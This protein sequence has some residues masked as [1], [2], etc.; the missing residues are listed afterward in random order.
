MLET[1]SESHK[2]HVAAQR[3]ARARSKSHPVAPTNVLPLTPE[4]RYQMIAEAAYFRAE[5]RGFALGDTLQ[6]WLEAEAEIDSILQHAEPSSDFPTQH[7]FLL[8]IEP[9]LDEWDRRLEAMREKAR[10]ARA[11]IRADYEKQIDALDVKR[12]TIQARIQQI[13][14]NTEDAWE[15]LKAGLEKSWDETRKA[16]EQVA[17][18]FK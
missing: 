5:K 10:S 7:E 8:R 9:Q 4:Q 6:D 1:S 12:R 2:S 15:D 11:E 17:S 16:L 14:T 3:A 13:R 18:R